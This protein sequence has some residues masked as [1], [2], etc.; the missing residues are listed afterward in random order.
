MAMS[1]I[2]ASATDADGAQTLTITQSGK[3]ADLT[4]TADPP[5]LSP[6]SA[7][8]SGTPG[9]ADAGSYN[10]VWTVTDGSGG[11]ATATTTLTIADRNQGPALDPIADLQVCFS[12]NRAISATD[13][14]GDAITFSASGPPWMTLTS[15]AQVGNVRTGNLSFVPG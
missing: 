5:G 8:I 10:I 12:G 4:F 11:S 2:D 1:A 7:S 6:R 14:D 9:F 3:P 15:N 13:P